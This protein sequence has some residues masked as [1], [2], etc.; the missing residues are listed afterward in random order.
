MI[1]LIKDFYEDIKRKSKKEVKNTNEGV[2][3]MASRKEG[4]T[5]IGCSFI[6]GQRGWNTLCKDLSFLF[7]G[8]MGIKV[9]NYSGQADFYPLLNYIT[10][11]IEG[12]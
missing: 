8:F 10:C 6:R 1:R 5:K 4:E 7:V 11:C 12:A 2:K 9:G 3:E